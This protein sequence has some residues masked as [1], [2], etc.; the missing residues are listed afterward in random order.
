MFIFYYSVLATITPPEGMALFTASAIA[1]SNWLD[2][3]FKGMKLTLS[4]NLIPFGFVF[5]PTLLLRGDPIDVAIHIATAAVGV[6]MLSA[7]VMGFF[8]AP[9]RL[10]E[11]ML[12]LVGAA[13][14]FLPGVLPSLVGLALCGTI[15]V[16]RVIVGGRLRNGPGQERG[17][18]AVESG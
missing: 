3:G 18:S 1:G 5:I 11:R 15:A 2:T 10:V 16:R 14:L 13:L 4:G 7:A 12:L 6:T 17:S 8:G 9:L